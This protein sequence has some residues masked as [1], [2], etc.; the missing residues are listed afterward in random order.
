MKRKMLFLVEGDKTEVQ[1]INKLLSCYPTIALE[2]YVIGT[3]IF[4]LHNI[5]V[6]TYGDDWDKQDISTFKLFCGITKP[7]DGMCNV[8][9]S[10]IDQDSFTDIYLLM[11]F[12]RHISDFDTDI[13]HKMQNYFSDP[14]TVGLLCINYPMIE[15]YRH[16][17][18]FPDLDYK[19]RVFH[20]DGGEHYKTVV[21]RESYYTNLNKYDAAMFQWIYEQNLNKMKD[22]VG[23]SVHLAE[24]FMSLL[25]IQIAK[26]FEAPPVVLVICTSL[27]FL[28][29]FK[30]IFDTLEPIKEV[31]SSSKSQS[32]PS[33][34]KSLHS[35]SCTHLFS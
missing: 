19:N 34:T 18:K 27:M 25:N 11:D 20:L 10:N 6:E 30:G 4:A 23:N 1:F 16:L 33:A 35:A 2:H 28:R 17:K 24:Q 31:C 13:I 21:G 32:E 14:T 9:P 5:L 8:L 26:T 12:E 15:S 29:F 22:L 3:N 7:S